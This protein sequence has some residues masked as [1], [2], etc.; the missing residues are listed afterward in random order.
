MSGVI[1]QRPKVLT[2]VGTRPELI[3]LCRVIAELDKHTEHVLVHTGQNYDYELNEIFFKDLEVRKADH[4][5]DAAGGSPAQT[6]GDA[7]SGVQVQQARVRR[8][9]LQAPRVVWHK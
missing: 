9:S 8:V 2:I 3:K 4:F 1:M 5:L 7:C 6:I